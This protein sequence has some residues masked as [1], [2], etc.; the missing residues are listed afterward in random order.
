[1]DIYFLLRGILQCYI[2]LLA[3]IV[4]ALAIRSLVRLA[5]VSPCFGIHLYFLTL[6][7]ALGLS[8]IF[9]DPA[10]E[11]AIS[12]KSPGSFYWRLVFGNQYLGMFVATCYYF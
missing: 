1:M 7:D 5:T 4:L 9:P 8:C 11:S 2:I 12:P 3:Q 6:E 10:L